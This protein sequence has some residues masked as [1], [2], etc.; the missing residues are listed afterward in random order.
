[1]T[2]PFY[3]SITLWINFAILV[4]SLFD[5]EFFSA[6]GIKEHTALIINA[7]IIKLVAVLNIALRVFF[8]DSKI[9]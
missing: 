6:I 7:T 5:S 3:K 9:K 8:T 1:M 4:L 2:K